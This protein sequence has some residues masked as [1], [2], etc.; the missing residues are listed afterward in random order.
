MEDE[1]T[2]MEHHLREKRRRHASKCREKERKSEEISQK[3]EIVLKQE[4]CAEAGKL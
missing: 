3:Q 4:N 2:F 1:S